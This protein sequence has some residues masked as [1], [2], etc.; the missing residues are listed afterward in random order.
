MTLN[1]C[2]HYKDL[3]LPLPGADPGF[4]E[5]KEILLKINL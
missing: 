5:M 4:Q 1:K 2:N 3:P